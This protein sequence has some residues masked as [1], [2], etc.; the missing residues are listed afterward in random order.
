MYAI[1]KIRIDW[2][3]KH[4]PDFNLHFFA[5]EYKQFAKR[6]SERVEYKAEQIFSRSGAQGFVV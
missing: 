5:N 2:T 6:R 3:M 4:C 1:I